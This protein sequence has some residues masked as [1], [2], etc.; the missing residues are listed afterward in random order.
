MLNDQHSNV[1][2][3]SSVS[4]NVVLSYL[5][6]YS[7]QRK[8]EELNAS[9]IS[10]LGQEIAFDPSCTIFVDGSVR[11]NDKVG[12]AIFSASLSL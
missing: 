7:S 8:K 6:D 3:W 4:T 9:P 2:P 5:N 11:A 10:N 1:F 12:A